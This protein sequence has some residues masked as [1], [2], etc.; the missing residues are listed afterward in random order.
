MT[1]AEKKLTDIPVGSKIVIKNL[2]LDK[3]IIKKLCLLGIYRLQNFNIETRT[4]S[5]IILV[6]NW[7]KVAI[8]S[9]LASQISVNIV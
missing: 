9:L 6:G 3:A 8:D 4:M 2:Y 7:G 1:Q 5:G